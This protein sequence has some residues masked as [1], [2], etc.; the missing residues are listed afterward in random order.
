[1]DTSTLN[2][3]LSYVQLTNSIQ[4]K[5]GS[6]HY[7]NDLYS[8][9]NLLS[10]ILLLPAVYLQ[11]I[12]NRPIAKKDSFNEI[13]NIFTAE[14]LKCIDEASLLRS[15]W[16]QSSANPGKESLAKRFKYP[17]PLQQLFRA[18]LPAGLKAHFTQDRK[19]D[20]LQ[21]IKKMNARLKNQDSK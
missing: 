18:P 14:E 13:R 19:Q 9:K 21:L 12:N 17:K 7:L 2:Y 15:M 4:K 8:F 16:D 6:N 5:L 20:L 11:A 10:E 3:G 1:M